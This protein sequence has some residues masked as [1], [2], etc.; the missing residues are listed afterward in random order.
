MQFKVKALPGLVTSLM[1]KLIIGVISTL[2]VV[3]TVVGKVIVK[4]GHSIS[5]CIR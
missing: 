1:T 5:F 4:G 2:M 3:I